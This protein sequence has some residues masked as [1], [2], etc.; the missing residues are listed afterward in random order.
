[1]GQQKNKYYLLN[2]VFLC[3]LLLLIVNDHWLK[4]SFHNWL[5]GKLSDIAGIIMLPLL[6]AYLLP[7]QQ[8]YS[9]AIAAVL[10]IFWKSPYSQAFID[11]YNR[12]S[13]IPIMRTV[14]YTDLFVLLLIPIPYFIMQKIDRWPLKLS[15]LHIAWVLS[16]TVLALAAT[17]PPPSFYYTR[18]NGNLHCY[19]CNITVDYNQDE[20]VEKLKKAQIL[21]DSIAPIDSF[22]LHKVPKLKSENVHVYKINQLILDKDTLSNL[23]F[24][25]RTI[26]EGKTRI[27]FNGMQVSDDISTFKL[28]KELEKYYKEKI[29]TAFKN[30]IKE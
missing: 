11:S 16:P 24:T 1:M 7:R 14:D 22:A 21:F 2:I 20:I 28:E 15:K 13:F 3:C 17:S 25:M 27:Y 23:D 4:Q 9:I 18:S 5:T 19:K 10:F 26:K 12:F 6:L 30:G 8:R 29:F